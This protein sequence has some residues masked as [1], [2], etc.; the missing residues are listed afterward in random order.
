MNT[1]P[2][3]LVVEDDDEFRELVS[4]F[5]NSNGYDIMTVSNGAGNKATMFDIDS[6]FSMVVAIVFIGVFGGVLSTYLKSRSE[7]RSPKADEEI[8]TVRRE[9]SELRQRVKTLERLVTDPEEKLKREFE[10]L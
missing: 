9:V 6:P 3:I 1:R 7:N 8:E 10:N 4:E 2:H 5:L